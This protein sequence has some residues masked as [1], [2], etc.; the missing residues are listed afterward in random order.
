MGLFLGG[1]LL[2]IKSTK[3]IDQL[4]N[5]LQNLQKDI[6]LKTVNVLSVFD[7]DIHILVFSVK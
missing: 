2:I 5:S 4:F 7:M 6:L 3:N 1:G